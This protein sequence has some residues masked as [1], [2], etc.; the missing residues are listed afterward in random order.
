MAGLYSIRFLRFT[1]KHIFPERTELIFANSPSSPELTQREQFMC[2][3]ICDI[4]DA[5]LAATRAQKEA[6]RRQ[7][8]YLPEFP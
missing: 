6:I 4:V 7:N 8:G 3:R 1:G 2:A 5:S